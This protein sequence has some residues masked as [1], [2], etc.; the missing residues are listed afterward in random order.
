MYFRTQL[1][2]FDNREDEWINDG[3]SIGE[4]LKQVYINVIINVD[5]LWA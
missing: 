2:H 4:I 3:V 5:E 1:K